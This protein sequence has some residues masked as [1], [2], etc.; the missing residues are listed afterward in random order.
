MHT[1]HGQARRG[2]ESRTYQVWEDIIRRCDNPKFKQFKDYGGRGI[3]IYLPWRK[4]ENFYK[5]VGDIPEGM[6][7]DRI[8][9]DGDY[10]PGNWRLATRKEQASNRRT[11]RWI[12]HR[13]E[14]RTLTQWADYLGIAPTTLRARLNKWSIE[15]SLTTPVQKQ[16]CSRY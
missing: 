3:K 4:F 7:F 12:E 14:T 1:I 13:G 15:R 9:N 2:L 11:N 8:D 5:D 6:T 16:R 10:E